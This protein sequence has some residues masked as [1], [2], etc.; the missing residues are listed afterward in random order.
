M[1]IE[2][3]GPS[4]HLL[5]AGPPEGFHSRLPTEILAE[6]PFLVPEAPASSPR[7]PGALSPELSSRTLLQPKPDYGK[8]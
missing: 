4:A 8:S 7:S 1:E 6:R 5:G 3:R 2:P